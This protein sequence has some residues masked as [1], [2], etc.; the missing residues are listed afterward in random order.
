MACSNCFIR[1]VLVALALAAAPWAVLADASGSGPLL[2]DARSKVAQTVRAEPRADA[3]SAGELTANQ[4]VIPLRR[5]GDWYYID[6]LDNRRFKS[7]YVPVDSVV[8]RPFA[9]SGN[10][11]AAPATAS[12]AAPPAPPVQA[13]E[14]RSDAVPI[15]GIEAAKTNLLCTE[16]NAKISVK[17]ELQAFD[18]KLNASRATYERCEIQLGYEITSDCRPTRPINKVVD[19]RVTAAVDLASGTTEQRSYAATKS[20]AVQ[21]QSETGVIDVSTGSLSPNGTAVQ[22]TLLQGACAIR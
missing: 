20:V 14:K 12:R 9:A 17:A 6:F 1:R 10:T 5:T 2:D 22:V 13:A 19:C 8:G 11:A 15:R 4:L 16:D 21:S 7:G 3:P 18:C